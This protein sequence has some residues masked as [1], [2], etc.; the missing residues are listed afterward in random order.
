MELKRLNQLGEW[1]P[2]LFRELK[3][4]LTTRNLFL[5]VTISLVCQLFLMLMG[6]EMVG[7]S[8]NSWY[9]RWESVFIILNWI[10]PFLLLTCGVYLLMSDLGKEEHRGTLNFIRLS[11]QSSQSIL[12]GKMLGVPAVLYLGI[13]LAIPLHFGSALAVDFPLGW[14]LEIY[15]LWGVGC[16]LFY[17]SG[18]LMTLL[19]GAKNGIQALAWSGSFLGFLLGWV[20]IY[21]INVIF[22]SSGWSNG[23]GNWYWFSLP[24]GYS[25]QL[26]FLWMLITLSVATY[27]IW[28][29]ANRIFRNPNSTVVSK[30]QSYW[31]VASV[32]VCLL[33][34]FVPPLNDFR[35]DSQIFLDSQVFL[36]GL[37]LF[38]FN[39][40]GLLCMSGVLSPR[41]QVL[42]DWARYRHTSN[43]TDKSLLHRS[44]IQD[45]I[46]GEKSPGLV[47]IA[48]NF[49]LTAAIWLPWILLG[50]GQVESNKDFT[51]PMALLGLLLT[52]NVIL[53]YVAIAQIMVF[54]SKWQQSAW[55][56]GTVGVLVG[57]LLAIWATMG[58]SPL[59]M[60]FLWLL[61]PLPIVAFTNASATTI[62]LGLL[63]QVGILGLLTLQLTRQFQK[64]GESTSKK[65]FTQSRSRP[66]SGVK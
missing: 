15:L 57:G 9:I 10:L 45:L 54:M 40:V 35:P 25:P 17:S 59:D 30:S 32:Q 13:I 41:P 48:I 39:P 60:P 56:V 51:V 33:G 61:S 31:L 1:N 7:D 36:G 20:Y 16:G 65:L 34:F 47:A 23:L 14:L 42:R 66:F 5:G 8:T 29:A 27:W 6:S 21:V 43:F 50:L 46:W 19:Y 28:Q 55:I 49:L 18:V 12:S 3:G 63:T 52:L 44:L 26:I 58:M 62:F 2:Q 38:V 4:Q 53:I 11:P 22:D 24:V 64:L 37:T